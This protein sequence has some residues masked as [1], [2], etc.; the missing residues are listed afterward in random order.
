[1]RQQ[2]ATPFA[3][4]SV[5]SSQ[6]LAY[7]QLCGFGGADGARGLVSR[8]R[9]VADRGMQP[10][11]VVEDFDE[12]EDRSARSAARGPCVPV[13]EFEL[14]RCEKRFGDSVVPALAGSRQRLGDAVLVEELSVFLGG[15]LPRFKGSSQRQHLQRIV[16]ARRELRL[17][18]SKPGSCA[19]VH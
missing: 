12:L 5:R 9:L 10:L 19:V 6:R 4:A 17:V 1:M 8:R 14:E 3:F 2:G 7:G 13:D 16:V 11:L 15:V 18:S